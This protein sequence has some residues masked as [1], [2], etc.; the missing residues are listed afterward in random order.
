MPPTPRRDREKRARNLS[1]E[2]GRREKGE[3]REPISSL[4]LSKKKREEKK[5][6][7]GVGSLTTF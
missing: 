4:A 1:K 5:G 2:Q 3:T 6:K 7:K